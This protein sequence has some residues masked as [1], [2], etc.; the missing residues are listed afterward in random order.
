MRPRLILFDVDGTLI[1]AAGAGRRAMERAF[2]E[3]FHVNNVSRSASVE[4]GGKTD[5]IIFRAA[6]GV[7]GIESERYRSL[8][9]DLVRCF[10]EKLRDEMACPDPRRRV[11]PG[12]R[13]LLRDLAG[14]K[15]THLG[16]LTGNVE[17]GARAKLEP[18]GLNR[19]FESGG[20]ASDD[21][22]RSRIARI[23]WKRLG[24]LMGIAFE[25]PDVTVIGDTVHDVECAQANG[26][27]SVVVDTGWGVRS[28]IERANPDALLEDLSDHPRALIA[29]GIPPS[30]SP[31]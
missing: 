15:E 2:R 19:Y 11:L 13:S 30:S 31:R 26:F 16:L 5:P 1:D 17:A 24:E 14:R 21:P 4:F 28:E 18:F 23:A 27:R 20:F 3:V 6:A 10:I 7:L 22:D 9:G 12:V 29:L 8:A 25:P